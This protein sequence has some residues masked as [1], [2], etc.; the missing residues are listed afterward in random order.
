MEMNESDYFKE[1]LDDQIAWYDAKSQSNQKSFKRLRVCEIV[2]AC[3]LPILVGL[4]ESTMPYATAIA[5]LFGVAIA[6]LSSVLA[7]YKFEENWIEYRN[8]CESLK[9]QRFLYMTRSEPYHDTDAFN[10]LVSCVEGLIS[11]ENSNWSQTV[12]QKSAEQNA[13]NT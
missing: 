5:G 10:R 4:P 2:L 7:L 6:I 11:K 13:S 3:S 9:H 8:T 1:R 12:R